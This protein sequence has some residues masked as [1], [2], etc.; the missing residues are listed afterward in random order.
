VCTDWIGRIWPNRFFN[1]IYVHGFGFVTQPVLSMLKLDQP[2]YK[3]IGAGSKVVY[4]LL[5]FYRKE[6]N[7]FQHNC[8]TFMFKFNKLGYS[9]LTIYIGSTD[10]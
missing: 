7:V 10:S 9:N 2:N 4:K 5:N 1:P 6:I 3:W 8:D